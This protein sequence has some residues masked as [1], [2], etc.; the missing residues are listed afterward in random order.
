M[1]KVFILENSRSGTSLFRLVLIQI[2]K[3]FR[4]QNVVFCIGSF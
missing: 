1:E 4:L 3:L 2:L